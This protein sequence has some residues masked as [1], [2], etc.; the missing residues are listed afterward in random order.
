MIKKSMN[1]SL[2]NSELLFH[3]LKRVYGNRL[4]IP[5]EYNELHF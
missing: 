3:I 4:C 1:E 2:Q 5:N